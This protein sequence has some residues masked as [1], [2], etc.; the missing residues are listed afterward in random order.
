MSLQK[1]FSNI[2]AVLPPNGSSLR[3]GGSFVNVIQCKGCEDFMEQI[4]N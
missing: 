3:T 2:S 4:K 1:V